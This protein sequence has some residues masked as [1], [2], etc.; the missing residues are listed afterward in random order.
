MVNI[1]YILF[2][3]LIANLAALNLRIYILESQHRSETSQSRNLVHTKNIILSTVVIITKLRSPSEYIII[4]SFYYVHRITK[5]SCSVFAIIKLN[6]TQ[7]YTPPQAKRLRHAH[8][9][10]VI[11]Y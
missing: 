2:T 10:Y 11:F 5:P 3:R 1:R 8:V 7:R 6:I 9:T 4:R